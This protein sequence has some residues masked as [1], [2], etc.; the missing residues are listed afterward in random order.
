MGF[1]AR[2]ASV[3]AAAVAAVA[4]AAALGYLVGLRVRGQKAAN[5]AQPWVCGVLGGLGPKATALFYD[6]NVIKARVQLF[7]AMKAGQ[8]SVEAMFAEVAAASTA[9]W[10]KEQVA[11]VWA[12]RVGQEKVRDQDHVACL[13]YT[14]P[15][16][17]GR[18]E[19]MSGQSDVD[20]T[21]DMARSAQAL[22]NGGASAL[23]IVCSTA[24]QFKSGML[25]KLSPKVPFL[26]MLDLTYDYIIRTVEGMESS[27]GSAPKK[28]R[29]GLMGTGPLLK[30]RIYE[31]AFARRAKAKHQRELEVL[32]PLNTANGEQNNFTEAI[33]GQHGIKAGYDSDLT[34][35]HTFRNFELLLT[36]VLKLHFAGAEAIVLGCTELPLLLTKENIARYAE[37]LPDSNEYNKSDATKLVLVNP[38]QVL[39]D[40]II[41]KS[42]VCR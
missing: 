16:I 24:H 32:T 37:R 5:R 6:E 3:A 35:E 12:A 22:V 28:I 31:E 10:T 7:N 33:F 40:E 4:S 19:F 21:E 2:S 30:F 36:E 27:S 15:T 9:L 14:N 25:A 42:L 13:M 26:D 23:C 11:A 29:V 38:A 17:P 18:P 41:R 20:P 34:C 39:G 8:E 1:D